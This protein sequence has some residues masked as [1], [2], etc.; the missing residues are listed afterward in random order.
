M[1]TKA[2]ALGIKNTRYAESTGSS[3]YSVPTTRNFTRLPV[4]NRQ[5][6]LFSQQSTTP[7]KT[8]VSCHPS[9]TLGSHNTNH[10]INNKTWDI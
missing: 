2:R 8:M 6:P 9:Y 3:P 7:E 4:V 10:L 5:Y 1:N